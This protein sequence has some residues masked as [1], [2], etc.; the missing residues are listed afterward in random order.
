M[1]VQ[2]KHVFNDMRFSCLHNIS[3]I[4]SRK[5]SYYFIL[6]HQEIKQHLLPVKQTGRQ[7]TPFGKTMHMHDLNV[8]HERMLWANATDCSSG[9]PSLSSSSGMRFQSP[10]FLA[11]EDPRSISSKSSKL[12]GSKHLWLIE[13]WCL[14]GGVLP[15]RWRWNQ[16]AVVGT[17]ESS[18]VG[19]P[20]F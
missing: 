20:L 19:L 18:G 7:E 2:Q 15:L 9:G 8:Q 4:I 14:I 13:T 12:L 11:K 16:E 1:M 5:C 10:F 17:R 3:T 6:N